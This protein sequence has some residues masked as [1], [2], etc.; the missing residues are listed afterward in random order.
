[1]KKSIAIT[2]LAL[3]SFLFSCSN[4]EK[5]SLAVPSSTSQADTIKPNSKDEMNKDSIELN[6]GNKWVVVPEMMK[7][8]R[9]M[10]SDINNFSE[11]EK[12]EL[13]DYKALGE[14]LQK[15]IDLLT[16][17]CTMEGKGHDELHKWLVPFIGKVEELNKAATKEN[18]SA[19]Y[20]EIKSSYSLVNTYFE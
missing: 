5:E 15:N 12:T 7:Y 18:A 4:P 13:K 10:E 17:N 6:N 11:T 19:L 14:R 1:M 8:I 16:S 9:T 20:R 2:V 3:P